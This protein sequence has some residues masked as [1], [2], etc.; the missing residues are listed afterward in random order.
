MGM[1]RIPTRLREARC[2]SNPLRRW[3]GRCAF[4]VFVGA[5]FSCAPDSSSGEQPDPDTSE[6]PS[7]T[8][9][10]DPSIESSESLEDFA[11]TFAKQ[12]K[13]LNG[14]ACEVDSDLCVESFEDVRTKDIEMSFFLAFE[15][16]DLKTSKHATYLDCFTKA[17]KASK[18]CIDDCEDKQEDDGECSKSAMDECVDGFSDD[19]L[20]ACKL[21]KPGARSVF[22]A[23]MSS[24]QERL[25]PSGGG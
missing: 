8:P 17:L 4:I 19:E 3:L 6:D 10:D 11:K 20:D 23:A 25:N 15:Q 5:S 24:L 22:L 9:S 21:K 13:K 1:E 14:F 16:K 12:Y 18:G 7:K 2:A